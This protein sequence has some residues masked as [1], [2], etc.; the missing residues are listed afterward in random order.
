MTFSFNEDKID[1]KHVR[2][3]IEIIEKENF[4]INSKKFR[5]FYNS[6]RQVVTGLVVNEKVDVKREFYKTLRAILHN[7][8]KNGFRKLKKGCNWKLSH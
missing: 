6:D 3:L 7:R 8:E 1:M 4:K 2:K 5:Y